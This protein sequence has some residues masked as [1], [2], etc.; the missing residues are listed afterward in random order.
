M[1]YSL[2]FL[3]LLC[4]FCGYE[5]AASKT[6]ETPESIWR[7]SNNHDTTRISALR[8]YAS[9]FPI[10]S[11]E[12]KEASAVAMKLA[13]KVKDPVYRAH[14][15]ILASY[16]LDNDTSLLL[17]DECYAIYKQHG[18]YNDAAGALMMK[19]GT[20]R[21]N[22]ELPLALESYKLALNSYQNANNT[23]GTADCLGEI[24][25][26]YIILGD[27]DNYLRHIQM[28]IKELKEIKA[29]EKIARYHSNISYHYEQQEQLDSALY[30][31]KLSLREFEKQKDT[32]SIVSVKMSLASIAQREKN[33]AK[34]VAYIDEAISLLPQK[35]SAQR[36]LYRYVKAEPLGLDGKF[37]EALE[38]ASSSARIL[39]K[40]KRFGPTAMAN[41]YLG[42]TYLLMGDLLEVN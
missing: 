28:A 17:F 20:H 31:A 34:S 7:N 8:R 5:S 38:A 37:Q 16:E 27:P 25:F 9:S 40:H 14:A 1:K 23:K 21:R 32:L 10:S 29:T 24:A 26:V 15:L 12:H 33:Y 2:L 6:S 3:F 13:K 19:A 35:D 42:N 18:K 39:E 11:N 41:I 36:A 30:Y 22:N 4:T